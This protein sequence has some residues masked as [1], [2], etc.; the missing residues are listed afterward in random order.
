MK[1]NKNNN[2]EIIGP[3]KAIITLILL[4]CIIVIITI[5]LHK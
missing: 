1:P 2:D 4:S 3:I 5:L